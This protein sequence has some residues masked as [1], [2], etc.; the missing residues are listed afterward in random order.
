MDR[1]VVTAGLVAALASPALAQQSTVV[2]PIPVQ[3]Q[4][5]ETQAGGALAGPQGAQTNLIHCLLT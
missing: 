1:R 4:P 5:A 2:S 3:P